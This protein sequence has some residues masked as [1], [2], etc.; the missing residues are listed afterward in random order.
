MKQSRFG[1]KHFFPCLIILIFRVEDVE[2]FLQALP[3]TMKNEMT[4]INEIINLENDLIKVHEMT[5]KIKFS[6][7]LFLIAVT[8]QPIKLVI[9]MKRILMRATILSL[10]LQYTSKPFTIYKSYPDGG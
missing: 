10:L 6:K 2:D 9:Q 8:I 7:I 3:L 5:L 4:D 1:A